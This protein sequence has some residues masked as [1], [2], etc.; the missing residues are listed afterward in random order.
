VE[1]CNLPLNLLR[2]SRI[3]PQLLAYA[4]VFGAFD[5]NRTPLAPPGT[6]VLVH[7]KPDVRQSWDPRAINAWYIGPAMQHCRCYRVYIWNTKSERI[8]D[9]LAWF[10]TSVQMLTMSSLDLALAAARDLL[11]A[12]L[13]PS[14]GSPLAPTT[15]SQSAAL[16]QLVEIFQVCTQRSPLLNASASTSTTVKQRCPK[17]VVGISELHVFDEKVVDHEGED[18]RQNEE[19]SPPR[20]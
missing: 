13:H 3:N 5:D 18:S 6:R 11:T 12:L 10:P 4:Q 20:V 19:S 17:L 1:Q 2:R 9:T 15:D 14:P 16:K 8:A 7:E